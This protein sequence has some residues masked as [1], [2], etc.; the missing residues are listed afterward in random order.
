MSHLSNN[1]LK[2]SQIKGTY[3]W[4]RWCFLSNNSWSHYNMIRFCLQ[5]NILDIFFYLFFCFC[6]CAYFV[7]QF[8]VIDFFEQI[9][10]TPEVYLFSTFTADA[11]IICTIFSPYLFNIYYFTQYCTISLVNYNLC[12]NRS[13]WLKKPQFKRTDYSWDHRHV[14]V[15]ITRPWY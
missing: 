8:M 15:A 12:G 14:Y 1:R 13:N 3:R 9:L 4:H 2:Q 10:K 7:L 5:N 11:R 6:V